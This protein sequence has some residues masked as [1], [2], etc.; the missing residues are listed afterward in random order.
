MIIP[1]IRITTETS[2]EIWCQRKVG[3]QVVMTLLHEQNK[4]R[5]LHRLT[6][7]VSY[8]CEGSVPSDDTPELL[9]HTRSDPT[10]SSLYAALL[11]YSG[12]LMTL[13]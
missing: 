4:V 8:G 3:V 11:L 5:V 10:T 9:S 1:Y 7:H 12:V 13:W 6:Q 2:T